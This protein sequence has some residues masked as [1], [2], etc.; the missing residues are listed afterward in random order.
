MNA[1]VRRDLCTKEGVLRAL[2]DEIS[3]PPH[4]DEKAR[5]R[6]RS[7]GDWLNRDNSTL[8]SLDPHISAQGSFM[9]GTVIRPL[10]DRDAYDV[11]LVCRLAAATTA[12]FTQAGLKAAVG[13]EIRSYVSAHNMASAPRDGR[14]CWT[15]DYADEASFHLDILPC[16]N[17][18]QQFRARLE[19][20]G[21]ADAIGVSAR[22]A[23]GI[24][25]RLSPGYNLPGGPWNISNPIGYGRW[26]RLRQAL[27]LE[28]WR[29]EQTAAGRMFASVE[30]VP[31]HEV[32]TPLQ[33]S[34][35]LLKRH[36]DGMFD[37][38]EDRPISIIISTLAARAYGSE[39]TIADTLAAVLPAMA[40]L[41]ETRGGRPWVANPSYP[42]ENFAD[43]W[44]KTPRKQEL[45]MRWLAQ[46]NRDFGE[47]LRGSRFSDIPADLVQRLTERTVRK[48]MARLVLMTPALAL[49]PADVVKAETSKVIADGRATK[50]WTP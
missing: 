24:T 30:D 50:P 41:I 1:P 8:K 38:D 31:N 27:V 15:L 44:A 34:I 32:R 26:F 5:G 9:L 21:V 42:L 16:L 11:D 37:G 40:G 23:V 33:D 3:I 22:T 25:D 17:A 20:A 12:M 6:Y 14:R 13:V 4:M 47:Y 43:K 45:F 35:K 10:G 7:I 46:A 28:Q 36:R 49:A 39:A 19:A 2:V 48:I 18:E 29:R